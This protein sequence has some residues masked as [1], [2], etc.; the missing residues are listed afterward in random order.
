M[1]SSFKTTSPGSDPSLCSGF[2]IYLPFLLHIWLSSAWNGQILC[3]WFMSPLALL[4]YSKN[5]SLKPL[6]SMHA[7]KK[8]LLQKST[9]LFPT[10]NVTLPSKLPY[11]SDLLPCA[12]MGIWPFAGYLGYETSW[13]HGETQLCYSVKAESYK[14]CGGKFSWSFVSYRKHLFPSSCAIMGPTHNYFVLNSNQCSESQ[15]LVFF[16]FLNKNNFT[17]YVSVT[18][19]DAVLLRKDLL[20]GR[21]EC[22]STGGERKLLDNVRHAQ[23]R[24]RC[25][26]VKCLFFP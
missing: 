21:S 17:V 2:A 5:P 20:P 19:G 23:R 25:N 14:D 8:T 4:I 24:C 9:A 7:N 13:R 16:F 15:S 11:H 6:I 18:H 12:L 26:Q 1:P 10:S 3:P 22:G